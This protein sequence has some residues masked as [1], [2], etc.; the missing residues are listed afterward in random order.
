MPLTSSFKYV[1]IEFTID[2]LT[3]FTDDTLLDLD[4]LVKQAK[5]ARYQ[6]KSSSPQA[7]CGKDVI[8]VSSDESSEI[9]VCDLPS[10]TK[11]THLLV[12]KIIMMPLLMLRQKKKEIQILEMMTAQ[13]SMWRIEVSQHLNTLKLM[14]V[15]HFLQSM[16]RKRKYILMWMIS[17]LKL[18]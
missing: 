17:L 16:K 14:E 18:M 1:C 3:Y 11:T 8:L 2:L 15:M 10:T 6:Q 5:T 13:S 12:L 7:T 9:E 4:G